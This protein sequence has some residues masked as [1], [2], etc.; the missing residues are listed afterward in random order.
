VT[1]EHWLTKITELVVRHGKRLSAG[2][3][4]ASEADME[5]EEI[6]IQARLDLTDEQGAELLRKLLAAHQT[7]A[8]DMARRGRP[9]S[10][11]DPDKPN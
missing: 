6:I 1:V 2:E 5:E 4:T 11:N 8:D 10:G 7:I 3:I 9:A